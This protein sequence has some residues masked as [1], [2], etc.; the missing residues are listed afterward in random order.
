MKRIILLL[1]V[2]SFTISS[3]Q[4]DSTYDE[5]IWEKCEIPKVGNFDKVA[6][7]DSIIVVLKD[8]LK[9]NEAFISFD[10]MKTWSKVNFDYEKNR[11]KDVLVKNNNIILYQYAF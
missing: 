10:N 3:A 8:Y 5:S 7:E 2:I 4:T 1:L 9:Y 11:I 6:V